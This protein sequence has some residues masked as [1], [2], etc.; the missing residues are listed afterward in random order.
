MRSRV[1]RKSYSKKNRNK[2]SY[3]KK[4]RKIRSKKYKNYTKLQIGGSEKVIL[5]REILK[6]YPEL[7]EVVYIQPTPKISVEYDKK[8]KISIPEQ[9][10]IYLNETFLRLYGPKH[11]VTFGDPNMQHTRK[12]NRVFENIRYVWED[13]SEIVNEKINEFVKSISHFNK[14]IHKSEPFIIKNFVKEQSRISSHLDTY[15]DI[16]LK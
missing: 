8:Y 7:T 12:F 11:I 14:G 13:C 15:K 16:N 9:L 4:N 10:N 1:S 5:S 3:S 2:K 6:K